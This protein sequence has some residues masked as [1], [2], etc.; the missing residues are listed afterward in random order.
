[1][2]RPLDIA[3]RKAGPVVFAI[4]SSLHILLAALFFI[5][6]SRKKAWL[7]IAAL[8]FL[9]CDTFIALQ[10]N[11]PINDLFLTWTPTTIP[12]NW[13]GI[14]DE[15]LSYHLY[16]NIFMTLGVAAILL[17]YFVKQNKNVTEAV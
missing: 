14:R 7:I 4:I 8:I 17:T 10:Y 2:H 16:R 9:L 15:W 12:T 13:A 11:G 3:I 5:E 6:K 1:M